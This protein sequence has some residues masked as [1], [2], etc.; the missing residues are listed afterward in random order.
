[1]YSYK[2]I[3]LSE[4]NAML[5]GE[6]VSEYLKLSSDG[7]EVSRGFHL[8]GSPYLCGKLPCALVMSLC[9]SV[10]S[11]CPWCRRLCLY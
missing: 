11:V 10:L 6:D 8:L 2:T 4:I 7:L 3:D 5:N 9:L 1:V